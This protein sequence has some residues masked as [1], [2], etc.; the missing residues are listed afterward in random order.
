MPE[1]IQLSRQKGYRKP[2]GAIVVTRS[3][4][5][6]NPFTVADAVAAEYEEPRRACVSHFTAW[7]EG[8]DD[9]PDVYV[10]G[11]RRFDRRWIREH[12][13]ELAGRALACWC[14]LPAPGEPD[15]CHAAV[16]L[17]LAAKAGEDHRP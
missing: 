8:H 3:T 12:L 1:R 11:S 2:E 4:R 5:W 7:V 6:G 15:H 17:D 16:L 9:Y 10:V 14:P 13:P